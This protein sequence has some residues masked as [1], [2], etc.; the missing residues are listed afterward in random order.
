MKIKVLCRNPRDYIRETRSDIH[1]MPR[2]LDPAMHPLESSRE[3]VRALNAT[4]LDK[5]FAKPFIGAL[6]G[7]TDGIYCM[8]KHPRKISI[9][10]SGSCDGELKVWN[11]SLKECITTL[12]SHNGFV[13]GVCMDNDGSHFI[14]VGDDNIIK[15]W[16]YPEDNMFSRNTEPISTI[17]GKTVY[18]GIDSHRYDSVFATCGDQVD[19]WNMSRSE[20]VSSFTWG[21]DNISSIKFNPVQTNILST[22]GS[23]RAIALYDIRQSSP[24]Q[25]VVLTLR[26]NAV[27]WNPIEAFHF[28]AANED[29]NL[30]TFDM[31][32]LDKP[33]CLHM[34]HVN[35]VLDVDYSPTGT[36]FVSGGFDK[37]IRI[38]KEGSR[39]SREIY[40]TKRMQ[41]I[42]C[43]KWSNDST[44]V[45]SGSDD[46]NIR[47]WKSVAS[48][49]LGRL[50]S[51]EKRALDYAEK[52][53]TKYQYH[54]QI[55]RIAHH[56]HVPRLVRNASHEKRIMLEAKRRKRRNLIQHSKPGSIPKTTAIKE[57]VVGVIQ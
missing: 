47:I 48:K 8:C 3:Y 6:S 17:L 13:R 46:M 20:P 30:Y 45:F 40:H 11:L 41:R 18:C 1:K 12:A 42:F 34:D 14:S 53:K 33:L 36:E 43:V 28:T 57:K 15:L 27:S 9:I 29:S 50:S 2:N 54:P 31:R 55:R 23:D 10:L 5:V 25:K 4:K 49:K 56:R 7:H 24:L 22:C 37:T 21:P 52:I 35:A 32:W 38:F 51:R 44:Y 19:I 16:Q 39:H 26:S